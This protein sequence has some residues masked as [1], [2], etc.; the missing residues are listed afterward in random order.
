MKRLYSWVLTLALILALVPA[1]SVSAS[2]TYEPYAAVEVFDDLTITFTMVR[3][4]VTSVNNTGETII[5]YYLGSVFHGVSFDKE[6]YMYHLAHTPTKRPVTYNIGPDTYSPGTDGKYYTSLDSQ[7]PGGIECV[8]TWVESMG[9]RVFI[10]F[11]AYSGSNAFD[12]E[13]IEDARVRAGANLDDSLLPVEK[14]GAT[15]PTRINYDGSA[16]DW[17]ALYRKRIESL[18]P[19]P[20]IFALADLNNDGIPELLTATSAAPNSGVQLHHIIKSVK[21]VRTC[22]VAASSLDQVNLWRYRDGTI[23]FNSLGYRILNEKGGV[24]AYKSPDGGS[25]GTSA[26]QRLISASQWMPYSQDAFSNA[27]NTWAPSTVPDTRAGMTAEITS[28]RLY[29]QIRSITLTNV[30]QQ[31]VD[32]GVYVGICRAG[33]VINDFHNYVNAYLIMPEGSQYGSTGVSAYAAATAT[34]TVSGGNYRLEEEWEI[35]L[36]IGG[37]LVVSIPLNDSGST[38][39]PPANPLDSAAD[40]AKTG[41]TAAIGKG[42]VPADIQGNYTNVITRAEFCRLAVRWLEVRLNK[43]IDAIVAE[44]GIAERMGHTFSD[45]TNTNILAAYRLGVTGGELAPTD[46]APGRF[47]PSGQFNREQAAM[48]ILNTVKVAGMDVS[49]TSSAGFNDIGT[50]SSWAVNAINYVRNA[51]IMSGTGT[52]DNPL[53]SPQRAYTR[54][55]SIV[56]FNN[57]G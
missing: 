9:E 6:V 55:E 4:R 21:S 49:N 14:V 37:G 30:T 31:M 45:T 29:N 18:S 36:Y 42:F 17:K 47:N 20:A 32:A 33:A 25:L 53:F 28:S 16:I 57:I 54:Q 22:T 13:R 7:V 56:T 39:P 35:R 34:Y 44:H 38:T 51:G 41:I 12:T 43:S 11:V 15:Q 40:W 10:V 5:Q 23:Y 19:S 50:A 27:M 52:A 26:D 1:A 24:P 3:G 8:G 48:M 46:A 2:E